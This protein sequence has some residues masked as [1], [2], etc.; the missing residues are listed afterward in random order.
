M[1]K[2]LTIIIV[3]AV[4]AIGIFALTKLGNKENVEATTINTEKLEGCMEGITL[5]VATTGTFAPFTYYDE[6]GKD[7]IGFDL[8]VINELQK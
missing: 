4:L 5:N 6:N 1:K 2:I 3:V 7:V 8:D